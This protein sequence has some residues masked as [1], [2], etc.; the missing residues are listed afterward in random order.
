MSIQERESRPE[1]G[2]VEG[3]EF[4]P[5]RAEVA[6]RKLTRDGEPIGLPSRV[7]D[8]LVCLLRHHSQV[9]DKDDLIKAGWADAFV[10]EDSL[11]H[12]ISVL[13]R[14]LGDDSNSPR[15]IV[16]L[17]RRGY[18][19]V[20]P[21]EEIRTI[22]DTTAAVRPP[23]AVEA[24]PVTRT[25]PWLWATVGLAGLIVALVTIWGRQ[26]VAPVAAAH[27]TIRLSQLPHAGT[28]LMSNGVSRPTAVRSRSL[29]ETRPRARRMCGYELWLRP[30]R[31]GLAAPREAR[32]RSGRLA[33]TRSPT[34]SATTSW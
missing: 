3:Y 17:P 25:R 8:L 33:R 20:G 19:F 12:G 28:V 10:S 7:F 18:Q 14:A 27:D 15:F 4:G 29:L 21:V 6:V 34:S 32:N 31:P 22:A 24:R 16:T 11:I 5:F 13:R 30:S 26:S 9:V 23:A 1:A 2:S